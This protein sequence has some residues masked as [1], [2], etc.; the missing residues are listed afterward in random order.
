MND[1]VHS[2]FSYNG[3]GQECLIV[4]EA[5]FMLNDVAT[6]FYLEKAIIDTFCISIL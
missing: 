5:H 4:I 3:E 2:M 1:L 6:C